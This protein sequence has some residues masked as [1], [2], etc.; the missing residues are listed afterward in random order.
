MN[1]RGNPVI[2]FERDVKMT[3]EDIEIQNRLRRESHPL[4]IDEYLDFLKFSQE[5]FCNPQT[6]PHRKRPVTENR[7]ELLPG[8]IPAITALRL[9]R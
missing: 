4:S 1:W 8:T 3:P 9:L 6:I 5:L 2:D 7:F